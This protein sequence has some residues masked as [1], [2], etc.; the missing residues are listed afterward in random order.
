MKKLIQNHYRR[1]LEEH[2][3]RLKDVA[4]LGQVSVT[5][6]SR[7]LNGHT[8]PTV[9]NIQTLALELGKEAGAAL[10]ADYCR[11]IIPRGLRRQIRIELIPNNTR[12]LNTERLP[13]SL[14]FMPPEGLEMIEKLV[15]LCRDDPESFEIFRKEIDLL[16]DP[17]PKPQ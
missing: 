3:G 2:G 5:T 13:G 15:Q 7:I 4:E 1:L 10:M 9:A 17:T 14:E 12:V 6:I 16:Y 11:D 8:F